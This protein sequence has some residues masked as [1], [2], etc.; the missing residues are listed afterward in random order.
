M[1]G[2]CFYCGARLVRVVLVYVN[3]G[4]YHGR[5]DDA[6]VTCVRTHNFKRAE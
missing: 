2:T 5:Y 4:F 3:G 6:C 1:L